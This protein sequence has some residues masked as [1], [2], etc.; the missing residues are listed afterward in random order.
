M[1]IRKFVW[2]VRFWFWWAAY[3]GYNKY[4]FMKTAEA[5]DD[6]VWGLEY[7]SQFDDPGHSDTPYGHMGPMEEDSGWHEP[8]PQKDGWLFLIII[9]LLFIAS[10]IVLAIAVTGAHPG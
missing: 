4:S 6:R 3:Y 9:A 7:L 5:Y 8:P 10:L 1:K 2:A